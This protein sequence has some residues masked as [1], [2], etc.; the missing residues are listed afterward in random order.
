MGATSIFG[1]G[2]NVR[3]GVVWVTLGDESPDGCR[4]ND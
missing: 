4:P 1:Y 3:F 2:V